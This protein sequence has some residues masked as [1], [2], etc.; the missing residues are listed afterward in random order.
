M[1]TRNS[2]EMGSA[3]PTGGP[4]G[5]PRRRALVGIA[6]GIVAATPIGLVALWFVDAARRCAAWYPVGDRRVPCL[7]AHQ[8]PPPVIAA[9]LV[10]AAVGAVGLVA[11]ARTI[12]RR[13]GR[14]AGLVVAA[15]Y[16]AV[17]VDVLLS[18]GLE[19]HALAEGAYAMVLVPTNVLIG[20]LT[21]WWVADSTTTA[22]RSGALAWTSVMV[23]GGLASL[24]SWALVDAPAVL[25]WFAPLVVVSCAVGLVLDAVSNG[26][27]HRRYAWVAVTW[28][29]PVL[30]AILFVGGLA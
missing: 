2:A 13:G 16:V 14:R 15:P 3:A 18:L 25:W 30:G 23:T 19:W 4:E 27:S 29:V 10:I 1:P 26:R 8:P 6:S 17:G 5:P 28:M 20:V 22:E 9:S 7:A 21:V 12:E 11:T 24:G